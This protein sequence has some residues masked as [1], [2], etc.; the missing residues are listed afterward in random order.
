M[1]DVRYPGSILVNAP[2]V[3]SET[4]DGEAII[5]HHGSGRYFDI[6]GSGAVIWS[7]I[8]QGQPATQIA[9]HLAA[10]FPLA[11][12]EAAAIVDGFL[13]TLAAH[14][15]IRTDPAAAPRAASPPPHSPTPFTVPV[16]GVHDDL[17]D[18]LLLDPIHDVDVVG[19]PA[20]SPAQPA[21]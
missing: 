8:E 6:S 10:A 3:V 7:A 13:D 17:A 15:L 11:Q 21:A 9:A 18:M 12:A 1:R 5:M 2:Q 16:L 14:D 19:W 20:P 4:I